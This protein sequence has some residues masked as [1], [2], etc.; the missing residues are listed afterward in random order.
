MSVPSAAR[1][2]FQGL[3]KLLALNKWCFVVKLFFDALLRSFQCN[4]VGKLRFHLYLW[5]KMGEKECN[6]G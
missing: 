4:F 3:G 5:G 2:N 6:F 1:V